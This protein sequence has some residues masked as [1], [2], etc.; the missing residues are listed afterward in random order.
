MLASPRSTVALLAVTALAGA[1]S[2]DGAPASPTPSGIASLEIVAPAGELYEGD[3]MRL[4]ARARDAEGNLLADGAIEPADLVWS[5]TDSTIAVV[6][7]DGLVRGRAMGPVGVRVRLAAAAVALAPAASHAAA[8]STGDSVGL[9]VQVR[10]VALD[11]GAY[12]T[13]GVTEI[14]RGYC[15]GSNGE[16]RL[17]SIS[18][19]DSAPR[20][21]HVP[22]RG[23]RGYALLEAG[24]SHTCAIDSAGAA[25]CWGLNDL[26]QLGRGVA[27][28]LAENV[29]P[30]PVIG[31][32]AFN[33]MA[34][35]W[36]QTC[37]LTTGGAL[38]CW[39]LGTSGRLGTGDTVRT[40]APVA[41]QGGVSFVFLASGEHHAC[42]LTSGGQ[43]YCWVDNSAGQL[44][45]TT[46]ETCTDI[47]GVT[48]PCAKTPT[49]VSATLQFRQLAMGRAHTCGVATDGAAYCWG[50]GEEGRLG[51]GDT[52][53]RTT[54]AL[55]AG[56]AS[57]AAITAGIAHTCAVATDG[58]AYCWGSNIVG[59]LGDGTTVDR[60]TPT[61]VSGAL[62]FSAVTGGGSHTCGLSTA[63][64]AYCWG[65]NF[66]G[67]LG[68]GAN[69]G[70]LVPVLVLGQRT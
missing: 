51:T 5:T 68:N 39:G 56:S 65:H 8:D 3:T 57:F 42:A 32:L 23:N 21:R 1:C 33:R 60:S 49:L 45:V 27:S 4:V 50:S 24:D 55:V 38:H 47:F 46:G 67:Q 53:G 54:P 17:G 28:G 7:A 26:G 20:N 30:A 59:N 29:D 58:A 12:H 18:A 15:W 43:A 25:Y 34:L 9:D 19:T 10:F 36:R 16:G 11:A 48:T 64:I 6:S 2:D 35:G 69:T 44:G 66:Q 37:G 14:G 61:P 62:R 70:S 22:V 52:A 41:A 13:C 31:G 63:G 40:A